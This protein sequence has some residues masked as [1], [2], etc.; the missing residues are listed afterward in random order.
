MITKV[1]I[2]CKVMSYIVSIESLYKSIPCQLQ[3]SI[4]TPIFLV[5]SDAD[6]FISMKYI[7]IFKIH[8]IDI[9]P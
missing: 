4:V 8:L 7:C 3:P 2:A 5:W 1:S 6:V 9:N